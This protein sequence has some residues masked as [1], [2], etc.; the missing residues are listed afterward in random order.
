[1]SRDKMRQA[2]KFR[3]MQENIVFWTIL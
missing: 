3:V 2:T 1:M